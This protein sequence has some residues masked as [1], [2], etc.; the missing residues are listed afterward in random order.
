MTDFLKM[1]TRFDSC[2]WDINKCGTCL[3]NKIRSEVANFYIQNNKTNIDEYYEDV[4][5]LWKE[6]D[7][8]QKVKLLRSNG[9]EFDE[10]EK[11]LEKQGINI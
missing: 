1:Y 4:E 5:K 11:V 8:Y 6:T 2:G 9:M 10:I 3:K 7:L